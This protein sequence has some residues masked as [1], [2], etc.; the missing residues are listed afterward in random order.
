MFLFRSATIKQLL[1][2]CI[3]HP[4]KNHNINF[5]PKYLIES[6]WQ[7]LHPAKWSIFISFILHCSPRFIL[8][9]KSLWLYY[10]TRICAFFTTEIT[11]QFRCFWVPVQSGSLL[12]WHPTKAGKFHDWFIWYTILGTS[13][14][15]TNPCHSTNIYS[16]STYYNE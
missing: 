5:I 6:S 4:Q 14:P 2:V 8:W 13:A 7:L 1:M 15:Q 12:Q 9:L 16:T 11:H 3:L 10:Q